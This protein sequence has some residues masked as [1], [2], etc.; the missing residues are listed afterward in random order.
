MSEYSGGVE[1]NGTPR[2]TIEEAARGLGV[3]EAALRKRIRRGS[4][5]KE[6]VATAG[7]TCTSTCHGSSLN[8]NHRQ[9]VI[10]WF[11]NQSGTLVGDLSRGP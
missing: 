8:L 2:V 4:L 11:R 9:T 10:P 5:V 1:Q 3:S 6:T 7:C